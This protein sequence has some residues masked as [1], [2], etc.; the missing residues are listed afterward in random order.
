MEIIQSTFF[1]LI[2]SFAFLIV[3]EVRGKALLIGSIGG[4]ISQLSLELGQLVEY[5]NF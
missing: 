4:A 3:F 2:A 1:A 5:F